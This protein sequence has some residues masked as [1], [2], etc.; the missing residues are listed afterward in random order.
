MDPRKHTSCCRSLADQHERGGLGGVRRGTMQMRAGSEV[1][2]LLEIRSVGSAGNAADSLG[3]AEIVS[4]RRIECLRGNTTTPQFISRYFD[5]RDTVSK[6]HVWKDGRRLH[7][8][9]VTSAITYYLRVFFLRFRAFR[10][11]SFSRFV[12]QEDS[13]NFFSLNGARGPLREN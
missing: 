9:R 2:I 8:Y 1:G 13:A 11:S 7:C 3:R 4:E 12:H 6:I 5:S 10:R